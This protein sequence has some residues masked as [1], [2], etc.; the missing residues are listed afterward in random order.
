MTQ[1]QRLPWKPVI[2]LTTMALPFRFPGLLEAQS[3]SAGAKT[4]LAVATLQ[5]AVRLSRFTQGIRALY[6]KLQ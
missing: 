5:I 1:W 3:S 2:A 4:R 6:P